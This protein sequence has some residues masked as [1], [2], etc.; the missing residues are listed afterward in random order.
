MARINQSIEAFVYCVLGA[1]V[2]VRSSILGSD[3]SLK[4]AQRECLILIEDAVRQ[5]NISKSVQRFQLA[6]NEAKVRLDLAISPG[7][8]LM[9]SNLIL[10]T[11]STIGYNNSL[12]KADSYMKM[13]V[14]NEINKDFRNVGVKM[15][16]GKRDKVNRD[17]VNNFIKFNKPKTSVKNDDKD[18]PEIRHSDKTDTYND[19]HETN[20]AL[21][22]I[23][24]AVGAFSLYKMI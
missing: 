24:A 5:P 1:Q 22:F 23:G 20:K 6:I 16:S 17:A 3:G 12:K 13:V 10:N 18:K 7:T 9:A 14:N 11:Q 21:L 19:P 8:W 2:N 4:E 15:M